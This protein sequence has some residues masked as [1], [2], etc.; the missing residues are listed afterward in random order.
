MSTKTPKVKG[1]VVMGR[2][3]QVDLC[4]DEGFVLSIGPLSLWLGS[5]AA[6]DVVETLARALALEVA[7]TSAKAAVDGN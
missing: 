5:A 6:L 1:P 2:I 3:V 4:P 7:E